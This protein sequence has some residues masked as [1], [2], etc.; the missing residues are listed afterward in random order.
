VSGEI[1]LSAENSGKH[2]DG[3]GFAPNPAVGVHSAPQARLKT[4]G[5]KGDCCPGLP[6]NPNPVLGLR[7]RFSTLRASFGSLS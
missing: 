4:A 5:R 3:R 1:I 6:K 7:P 2:L